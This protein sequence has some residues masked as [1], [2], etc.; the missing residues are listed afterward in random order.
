M[1]IKLARIVLIIFTFSCCLA[2]D[3][4]LMNATVCT[5]KSFSCHNP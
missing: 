4:I 1:T 5:I 3:Y 2:I